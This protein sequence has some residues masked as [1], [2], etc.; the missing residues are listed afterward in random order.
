MY[1]SG[2][3]LTNNKGD[4]D[5][6]KK[7]KEWLEAEEKLRIEAINILLRSEQLRVIAE[8]NFYDIEHSKLI[9][10]T[11]EEIEKLDWQE[12]EEMVR[13]VEM[14]WKKVEE[15][16]NS[17]KELDIDYEVLRE[18]VNN[19]YGTDIMNRSISL[20]PFVMPEEFNDLMKDDADWWKTASE[21]DGIEL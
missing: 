12:R 13:E 2:N 4:A 21:S 5:M 17:L 6:D 15:C 1:I 9:R 18:K 10:F 3:R 14:M 19:F 11:K 7:S 20:K 16:Y 8:K